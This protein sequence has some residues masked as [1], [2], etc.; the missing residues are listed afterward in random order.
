VNR[1]S[2]LP[3]GALATLAVAA[4]AA[5]GGGG[6]GSSA[7]PVHTVAIGTSAPAAASANGRATGTLTIVY[8]QMFH[9]AKKAT[10]G[11]ARHTAYVNP[12]SGTNNVLDIYLNGTLL[13]NLDGVTNP[14]D[15][16]TLPTPT[17][18]TPPQDGSATI[19]IPL[20]SGI[21]NDIAVVEWA[22]SA[23]HTL[24]NAQPLAL[25]ENYMQNTLAPGSAI[26]TGVQMY[27]NATQVA[28][29]TSPSG[30]SAQILG[31]NYYY[32]SCGVNNYWYFGA[33]PS[34]GVASTPGYGQTS[35]GY[36][37]T[38]IPIPS[39]SPYSSTSGTGASPYEGGWAV[40]LA[41]S[42]DE[43]DAYFTISNPAYA[44]FQN[45]TVYP[46]FSGSLSSLV[47]VVPSSTSSGV[48]YSC[49]G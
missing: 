39:F 40:T 37:G 27:M 3:I 20:Y 47:S 33:D 45:G 36:A 12:G 24:Y 13:S 14:N 17:P 7:T 35:T 21:Y 31:Y 48:Y 22:D 43:L 44:L 32:S 23:P 11:S 5:C 1:R 10:T 6:A 28:Q 9:T 49:G 34:N 42:S 16:Y 25:G 8:P 41:N 46:T 4:L 30:G 18:T 26:N 15:S 29:D 2:L 38:V 19:S